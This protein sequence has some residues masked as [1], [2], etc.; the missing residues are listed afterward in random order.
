MQERRPRAGGR[1]WL[2]VFVCLLAGGLAAAA[3][4]PG[5]RTA[6]PDR[7]WILYAL[8]RGA[9]ETLRAAALS[10][11][12]RVMAP[13]LALGPLGLVSQTQIMTVMPAGFLVTVGSR[14]AWV[15]PGSVRWYRPLASRADIVGSLRYLG[16]RVWLVGENRITGAV[17]IYRWRPGHPAVPVRRVPEGIVTL[18][19]GPGGTAALF[20]V[21]P[22]SAIIV[23]L[24][25]AR[26]PYPPFW[27]VPQGTVGFAGQTA[28]IPYTAGR[29]GFG[30]AKVSPSGIA[31]VTFASVQRAVLAV[32]DTNP[33]WGLTLAGMVPY[34]QRAGQFDWAARRP[35]PRRLLAEPVVVGSGQ[36]WILVLDGPADGFWF[37]VAAGQ[38]GPAFQIK[39]PW[40]AV[41]RAMA[42]RSTWSP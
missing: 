36:P 2:A 27:G 13:P 21:T 25:G 10:P 5:G 34:R 15:R 11:T 19:R 16:G 7:L 20:V 17:R 38:F 9:G 6:R 42:L 30:L 31:R 14:V 26:R 40:P 32:T 12:G 41:V 18:E 39:V 3:P 35:W 28:L 4:G 23:P 37:N 8:P 22:A 33:V 24:Q 1:S 29:T